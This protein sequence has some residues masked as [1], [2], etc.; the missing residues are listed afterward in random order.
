MTT[1]ETTVS[2]I[3]FHIKC[4]SVRFHINDKENIEWNGNNSSILSKEDYKIKLN[5]LKILFIFIFLNN[6]KKIFVRC[7]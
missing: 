1:F 6:S 3:V 7:F 2:V 5:A 4:K